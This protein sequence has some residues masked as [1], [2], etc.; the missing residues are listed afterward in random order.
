MNI[1]AIVAIVIAMVVLA[2]VLVL[3]AAAFWLSRGKQ[4]E[5]AAKPKETA[6]A[7]PTLTVTVAKPET[8]ELSV[9]LAANGN[10]APWQEASIGSESSGL[11]LAEVRVNVGDV[12]QKG[13]V[14][15]TFS[16]ETIQADVAQ[17]K[18]SLAEAR[19]TA[20]DAT[21]TAARARTLQA[22]GAMSQQ[23][24]NQYQTTEKTPKARVGPLIHPGKTCPVELWD[25]ARLL[26]L[27]ARPVRKSWLC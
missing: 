16:G 4:P 15:A 3:A 22:T 20:A 14:L 26:A 23:Q 6:T 5:S 10:V 7:R 19:A 1:G 2:V 24:I 13:Q 21:G 25:G 8:S 27:R 18:A 11:K 9:T 12:V 17:A